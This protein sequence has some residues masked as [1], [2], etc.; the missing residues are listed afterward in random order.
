[1]AVAETDQL[2]VFHVVGFTGHRQ[3]MDQ[4]RVEKGLLEV[5]TGLRRESTV[6]GRPT[7]VG[8][9]DCELVSMGALPSGI[10]RTLCC[11]CPFGIRVGPHAP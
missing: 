1:M 9:D 3:L 10:Y 8:E 6:D 5:L 2:P 11:P 4:S 7:A